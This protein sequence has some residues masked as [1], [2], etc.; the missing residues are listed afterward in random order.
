[1]I[2]PNIEGAGLLNAA[3]KKWIIQNPVPKEEIEEDNEPPFD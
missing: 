2:Y 1:M 3:I